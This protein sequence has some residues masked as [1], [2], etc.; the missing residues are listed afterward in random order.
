MD[1][2]KYINEI[3]K[4]G[5]TL[6]LLEPLEPSIEV[7]L[8]SVVWLDNPVALK[9]CTPFPQHQ[10]HVHILDYDSVKTEWDRDV[11]FFRGDVMVAGI[12]TSIESGLNTDKVLEVVA[13]WLSKH[14]NVEKH[15]RFL[16]DAIQ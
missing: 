11:L 6:N 4:T 12:T 13:E 14:N 9:W 5:A 1:Y 10:G 16:E 8:G 7:V 3:V 2:K 15:A